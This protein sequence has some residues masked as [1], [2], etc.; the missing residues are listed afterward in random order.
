MGQ[1]SVKYDNGIRTDTLDEIKRSYDYVINSI[2]MLDSK[3]T[4][5][6]QDFLLDIGKIN[7]SIDNYDEFLKT[8]FGQPIEL[9][10]IS[11]RFRVGEEYY[12]TVLIK[13]RKAFGPENIK[14]MSSD[15][16][17]LEKIVSSFDTYKKKRAQ[18]V[19]GNTTT[20]Y[21]GDH[22]EIKDNANVVDSNIGGNQNQV[23]DNSLR[24]A[25]PAKKDKSSFFKAIWANIVS[26]WLWWAIGI[27]MTAVLA[28]WGV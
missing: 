19:S 1:Y 12:A 7:A 28:K 18:K 14:I 13:S 15:I 25:E 20:I 24:P 6:S 22:I 4:V 8:S 5:S 16:G 23:I 2:K 11:I 9:N 27:I 17:T 21:Q 26:N 10:E 3:I